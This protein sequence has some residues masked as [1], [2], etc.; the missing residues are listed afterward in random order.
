MFRFAIISVGIIC[1]SVAGGYSLSI[2]HAAFNINPGLSSIVAPKPRG[3]QTP[4]PHVAVQARATPPAPVKVD[5]GSNLLQAELT[6]EP[7]NSKEDRDPTP[8]FIPRPRSRPDASR[9][10]RRF[11]D[12]EP[13]QIDLSLTHKPSLARPNYAPRL[14]SIPSPIFPR[15]KVLI[16]PIPGYL[17]GVF[18]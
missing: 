7:T 11:N 4:K 2:A 1:L 12:F 8:L 18:R 5:E 3:D 13:G 6:K 15:D 16:N 10:P 14:R 17:I 9:T